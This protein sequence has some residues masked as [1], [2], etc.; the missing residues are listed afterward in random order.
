MMT[1]ELE[2]WHDVGDVVQ[3]LG[4]CGRVRSIQLRNPWC[5]GCI[6]FLIQ[7]YQV[8]YHVVKRGR[9]YHEWGRIKRGKMKTGS[10]I[11]FPVILRLLGRISS[12]EGDWNFGEENKD[13][14]KMGLGKNIK[15]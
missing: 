11:I 5:R 1:V 2:P 9:K 8:E 12:V 6:K 10:N 14:K 7:V 13:L 3:R 4:Q 15:L